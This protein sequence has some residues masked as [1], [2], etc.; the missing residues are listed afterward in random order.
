MCQFSK[1]G[2]KDA[3]AV[4]DIKHMELEKNISLFLSFSPPSIFLSPPSPLCVCVRVCVCLCNYMLGKVHQSLITKYFLSKIQSFSSLV[5]TATLTKSVYVCKRELGFLS[6]YQRNANIS[7]Q[8]ELNPTGVYPPPLIQSSKWIHTH[9]ELVQIAITICIFV[10]LFS[11][12]D[13]LVNIL[14]F[15]FKSFATYR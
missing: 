6:C 14:Y 10:L 5:S 1:I 3:K 2:I 9:S 13:N 4:S 11:I 7:F 12:H 8:W 15:I